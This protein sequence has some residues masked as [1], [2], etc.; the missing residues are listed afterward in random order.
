MY[1]IT[2]LTNLTEKLWQ[3][4]EKIFEPQNRKRK[5]S[6]KQI[7]K[8]ILFVTKTGC[9]WRM[10]PDCFPKWQLVYY[11]FNKWKR[12]G[13]FEEILEKIRNIVRQKL[14]KPISPSVGIIDTQ[15]VKTACYGGK[16]IGIDG[17]KKIN[18]RKRQLI[19][20]T[21]GLLLSV[22]VHAANQY[23]GNMAFDVIKTLKYRFERMKKIFADGSY[24]NEILA[25]KLK[26]ELNYDLQITF[27]SDKS[28]T[29]KPLP[30]RWVIE[31]CFAWLNGFRRLAK[32]FEKLSD[33]SETIIMIAFTCLMLNN[34][35]FN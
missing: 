34:K 32:D 30:K 27:R 19:T 2:D 7:L 13:I 1:K 21:N 22:L 6:L 33:T 23:D 25:T 29:F 26:K 9:Q 24:R 3:S 4:S 8:A 5:H 16:N 15:S 12:E 14:G 10:L 17:G 11:Y 35:V 20:D 18:G 31:R 28:T